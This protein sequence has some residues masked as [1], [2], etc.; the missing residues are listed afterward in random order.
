MQSIN[1]AT[2]DLAVGWLSALVVVEH[3]STAPGRPEGRLEL[4]SPPW[5][6][7]GMR[8][9]DLGSSE[10]LGIEMPHKLAQLSRRLLGEDMH[11]LFEVIAK[12]TGIATAPRFPARGRSERID[13]PLQWSVSQCC[14]V[15]EGFSRVAWPEAR[16]FEPPNVGLTRSGQPVDGRI[17]MTEVVPGRAYR[18]I[19]P[20]GRWAPTRHCPF[21]RKSW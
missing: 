4:I 6:V 14:P 8:A 10:N 12:V 18:E 13:D 19:L 20:Y 7:E 11:D 1:A 9:D 17:R 3:P 16:A 15:P 2:C 21:G 5:D